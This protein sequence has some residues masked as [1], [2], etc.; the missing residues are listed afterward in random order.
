LKAR[1]PFAHVNLVKLPDSV[2][3][4]QAIL[5]SDIAPTG[6]F[7]ADLAEI[8]EGDNVAVFGCGPVGQF[9][10]LRAKLLGAGR[11]FAVDRAIDAVG[12]DSEHADHGPAAGKAKAKEDAF[13][14]EVEAVAPESRPD[15]EDWRPGNAPS[16]ALSWAVEALA[17]AGTLSIIDVY[18]PTA[19]TFPIGMAMLKNLTIKM[20]NCN[21]RKYIPHLLELVES[22]VLHP[23]EIVSKYE[24]LS[25]ALSA[26]RA[27]DKH[28]PGWMKVELE[29]KT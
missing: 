24:G 4:E 16:Q 21:H 28:Q 13:R 5:L 25:D 17:K 6:Y 22:E 2:S 11:V 1:I 29:P 23:E 3:D 12:V 18:P 15:G 26:Y 14:R 19:Q 27:F 7:G 8:S 20:G 9:A 10:I